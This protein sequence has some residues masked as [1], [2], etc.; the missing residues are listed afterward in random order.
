MSPCQKLTHV[1][2]ITWASP[3]LYARNIHNHGF[4]GGIYGRPFLTLLLQRQEPM[5][6]CNTLGGIYVGLFSMNVL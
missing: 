5:L 6:L 2:S 3:D 4:S 1:Y